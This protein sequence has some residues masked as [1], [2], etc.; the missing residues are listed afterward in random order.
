MKIFFVFIAFSLLDGCFFSEKPWFA[1]QENQW[2]LAQIQNVEPPYEKSLG[3]L[4]NYSFDQMDLDMGKSKPM[5]KGKNGIHWFGTDS[6]GRDVLAMCMRGLKLSVLIGLLACLIALL[7]SLSI[8]FI[9]GLIDYKQYTFG[10]IHLFVVCLLAFVCLFYSYY[11]FFSKPYSFLLL[12]LLAI[13]LMFNVVRI[14]KGA[15]LNVEGDKLLTSLLNV[16]K[17]LP[18]LLIVLVL[19]SLFER[20]GIWGISIL[21]GLI[22][23]PLFTRIIRA[24]M[25]LVKEQDYILAAKLSNISYFRLFF[26]HLLINISQ[27]LFI[28]FCFAING[29]ILLEATLSFLGI[30]V[31]LDAV[32]LGSLI[33]SA[34]TDISSWWLI[35]FPGLFL[36]SILYFF[37]KLSNYLK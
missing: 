20:S 22:I 12:V 4:I 19:A 21:I 14:N 33:S 30:G 2:K 6:L 13:F 32:T 34:R 25:M 37:S 11:L 1:K 8:N 28:A 36:L 26:R 24:E 7:I 9:A 15:Q 18:S 29:V 16:F 31:P 35:V 23:W 5:T 3:P 27:P 10:P 17:S